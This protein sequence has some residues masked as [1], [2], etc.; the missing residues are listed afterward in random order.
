MPNLSILMGFRHNIRGWEIA[1]GPTAGLTKK[2]NV[3]S[4]GDIWHLASDWND[5]TA[6]PYLIEKRMDSRGD[7]TYHTGF[8][9]AFG[10]SFKSGNMNFP[11]NAF[12]I[13]SKSGM[14]FGL[15][16]GFNAKSKQYH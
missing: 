2:A 9:F 10:K 14:R 16:F 1:L 5:S 3:Y 11:V 4:E 8:V 15:T 13:P 6:N 12:V 7:I